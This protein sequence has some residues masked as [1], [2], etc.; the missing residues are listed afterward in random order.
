[1]YVSQYFHLF[2]NLL[3]FWNIP[4]SYNRELLFKISLVGTMTHIYRV[5]KF[6][7][8]MR[9]TD[10]IIYF[11]TQIL[12]EPKTLMQYQRPGK[13]KWVAVIPEV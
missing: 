2:R 11:I 9:E 7:M 13:G 3:S 6:Y 10:G 8:R 4:P 1:M 5:E 12:R